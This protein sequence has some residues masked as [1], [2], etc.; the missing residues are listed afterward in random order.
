MADPLY[1]LLAPHFD[2]ALGRPPPPPTREITSE[3][4]LI[5]LT[6]L[7]L[8]SLTTSEPQ[9][10]SQS[11]HQ[12]LLAL[13][14]LST[15]SHAA[16]ISSTDEL[17]NLRAALPL[18]TGET[19]HLQHGV[20]QL[21][22]EALR[23]SQAY[24]KTSENPILDRRKKAL[25]LS[26]NVDRLSDILDLPSLLESAVSSA[27]SSHTSSTQEAHTSSATGSNYASALDLHGHI[28]RLHALYPQSPLIQTIA[29]QAEEAMQRMALQLISS[30]R[31]PGIRLAGAM[32]TIGWLR[33]VAPDLSSTV[34]GAPGNNPEGGL[35]A[36]FLVCRLSNLESLLDALEPLRELADQETELRL[37]DS[38]GVDA[39]AQARAETWSHGQQT[40]RYLKRYIE[41]F[42]EQSFAIISMYRSIFPD[43]GS[44]MHKAR[45]SPDAITRSKSAPANFP[46]DDHSSEDLLRPLPSAL[47]TFPLH[48][49]NLLMSTLNE[50]L[51]NVRDKGSRESLLTQLLYCAGSL[52]RLGADFSM[53]LAILVDAGGEQGQS[54]DEWIDVVKKHRSL[55]GRL[56]L[57]A[58]GVGASPSGLETPAAKPPGLV[59]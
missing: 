32:R 24:N 19:A 31:A 52:G 11:L 59:A 35:G 51:P 22:R 12:N 36:L 8:P 57:M 42:R 54:Q 17:S 13:Q 21:E 56:E 27:A 43:Q 14:N 18:L 9:S 1:E 49:V 58:S 45:D 16:I 25:L 29:S 10:L 39:A 46:K 4:Y 38:A 48:L 5:R 28:R 20:P 50:Y 34:E 47:S 33:R 15:R 26:R 7:N 37:S 2:P 44:Q 23:F 55:A 53:I 40:E 41:T 30:L 6:T 3:D